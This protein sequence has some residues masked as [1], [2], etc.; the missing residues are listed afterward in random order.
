MA[1]VQL[2]FSLRTSSN[3]KTVHLVGSWDNYQRQIPLSAEDKPGAWVGKFRFQT[4]MLQLGG[5]YWYYYIMDGYHVSHD[6][7]VEYT[8]E[9]TTGRKLNILDVPGGKSS[10][11]ST[12]KSRSANIATGR[13]LSP[14][15]IQHPKPSKPYASRQLRE[16]DFAPTVDDLTRRFAGSRLS[17]EYSYSNSPP[18]SAG[19]S[20]SSR[21]SG[22]TSP[23][24]LSSMSDPPVQCRCER[25]G[26]TRKGDRVKLDCGGSRCG[27]LTESSDDSCSE[28]EYESDEEYCRARNAARRQGI[29]VRR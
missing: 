18:S 8:V 9:P 12:R 28:S 27:Y 17:D 14:S 7:A 6:P 5:R 16:A 15:R 11:T 2:K 24:S 20:L 1:A 3:V 21:S 22:S 13:A 25:Y 29:V 19:S 23:S 4:S 10:S 26:I